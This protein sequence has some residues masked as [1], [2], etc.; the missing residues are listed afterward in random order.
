MTLKNSVQLIVYPDSLGGDLAELHFV[1]RR[2]LRRA[3][4]GIHLLPFYPSSA[5]RG[6]A[7]LTYDE[8]DP[9]FGTWRDIELIGRE[10]DLIIDFMVNHISRQSAYF[11]D[12]FEKGSDSE[13]ADMFLSFNKLAPNGEID[14]ADLARVYTRKP[15]P[16]YTIV[17]RADGS[18]E[19]VWCTFDYEQIDLDWDSP[20]T[21]EV[22]R[23]F[24]IQLSRTRAKMIRMDAFAY[25]TIKIGT[26]CFFLEPQV[27]QL[28]EWLQ[29]YVSPF[30]VEILP[31]VHEH[32]S[33]HQRISEHGYWTY[34]FSLPMLVLH[35]LYHHTSRVL[36]QWL[37]IC[38]RRQVTTLDTH[39]GIGVVDVQDLLS[40]EELERTL[41]GLDEKGA[42]TR[43]IFSGP[44]FQNL[45]IYQVNCTYY[46]ALEC[47]DD[48]Y[49][50]ARAIQF[51]TPG[52]PQVYYVGLLAG[53]NDIEL[54]QQTKNGRDINRHNFTLDE[55]A[56]D[57]QKPVVQRL[58]RLMEFRSR[59]PAFEGRFA[60]EDA[61]DDQLRLSWTQ[62]PCRAVL[63]IS[64]RTYATRITYFDEEKESMA[65][66]VA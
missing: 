45:D 29:D 49:I 64:L 18:K 38:P 26:N 54:V 5:D 20:K 41:D 65:E 25:C 36:K 43:K 31:E 53:E 58:L 61:P 32:Y 51:F 7:P 40:P 13:Y 48:S 30:D 37:A 16:P 9:A 11:Q 4:G 59:Y 23:R 2:Y 14:A 15:R 35:T 46:S 33:Y 19:K 60:I 50:A 66:F 10:F 62:L 1:L 57:I 39:D 17:Q 44:E 42:N 47:N 28:L 3:I 6:F 24:L 21:H 27:W 12:Y 52:I 22:M 56:R 8:V 55:I 63:Q 34:D